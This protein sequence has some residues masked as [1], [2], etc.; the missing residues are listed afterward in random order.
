MAR[1]E[2]GVALGHQ[3]A[4]GVPGL[5]VG[6]V[7]RRPEQD[8]AGA[9][10]D[11]VVHHGEQDADDE[12]LE[13]ERDRHVPQRAGD[14]VQAVAEQGHFGDACEYGDYDRY[15]QPPGVAPETAVHKPRRDEPWQA[16]RIRQPI[17][18]L[19]PPGLRRAG[20]NHSGVRD[21]PAR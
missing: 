16:S 10:P 21:S 6:A 4:G 3:L 11:P 15:E 7:A 20:G 2:A 9:G 12:Q 19:E 14:V 17:D 13:G 18:A 8:A 5:V 1:H